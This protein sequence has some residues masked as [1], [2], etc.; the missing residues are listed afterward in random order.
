M[1]IDQG[2]H[3]LRADIG[4]YYG[5]AVGGDGTQNGSN[6]QIY[7]S[8]TMPPSYYYIPSYAR[9]KINYNNDGTISLASK[10]SSYTKYLDCYKGGMNPGT[11]VIVHMI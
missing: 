3:A 7:G 2:D 5:L 4:G 8:T 9:W 6:V 10:C 11:N 1:G